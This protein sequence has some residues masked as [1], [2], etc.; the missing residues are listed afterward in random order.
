ML[1]LLS[2]DMEKV[3]KGEIVENLAISE[4]G[5][6]GNAMARLDN[7]VIF[8]EGAVPGDVADVMIYRKKKNY[9]E[10]RVVNIITPSADRVTP[11]CTHFGT[12]GGCKWQHMAYDKQIFFKQ[13][14]VEDVLERI[15]KIELP[16][17]TA[18]K[19]SALTKYYRNKL[20][21]TFSN[22]AWLTKEDLDS[23]AS[24]L[25]PALGFHVP[26]RFDKILDVK[27]CFL[28]ED[29]SNKIRLAVREF[30][31]ANNFE[32][33]DPKSQEGYLRNL[34]I[35]STSTGEWMVVVVF[36]KDDQESREL[37]LNHLK[38]TFPQITSLQY[39]VNEKRND[40][41]YDQ[42]VVLFN[43]RTYIE[44]KM[45][46]L[47]FRISAKS[48]YQTNSLQ[49]YE[50]YKIVRDY[51]ALTGN[52]HVYDL[53]TGTGTIAS[54]VAGKAKR[55]IGIDYVEDAIKDA[56]DNAR[57]NKIKNVKFLAGDIKDTLTQDFVA[58]HG[59]PDVVITDPPRSGMHE[60][61]VK[62]I[63]N[64]APDRIVYVSCNPSSQAR[65]LQI[66]DNAYRV[67][68]YQPVDMF[69]H[70]THVENV[71]LLKKR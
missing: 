65:D 43:G 32:F 70:T 34:I 18:I 4:A 45:E 41:I 58:E 25:Q 55:V 66:L 53:Y 9:A 71:M 20:E 5:A 44:E 39:I 64:N 8:A 49:A 56:I 51:A 29:L 63:V 42:D 15:G 37:L 36:K 14:H 30:S 7:Y 31:I 67:E 54:F 61:V 1:F 35:R 16:K 38:N 69:P 68:Q 23:G 57:H 17:A 21:Y 40:T 59:R 52:E 46:E 60:D 12:C 47:V 10:G 48:F 13:K 28:Q 33:F 24:M 62:A 27:E 11:F 6:E 19:G 2:Q 3:K 50:L 22:K 26:S